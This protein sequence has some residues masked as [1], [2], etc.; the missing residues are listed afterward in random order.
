MRKSIFVLVFVTT[1]LLAAGQTTIIDS[2]YRDGE[3]WYNFENTDPKYFYRAS[4]VDSTLKAIW[5]KNCGPLQRSKIAYSM[6]DRCDP[7]NGWTLFLG[8]GSWFDIPA[9]VKV[10]FKNNDRV[11]YNNCFVYPPGSNQSVQILRTNTT[12]KT[13]VSDS[14]IIRTVTSDY[15][16]NPRNSKNH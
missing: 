5:Q 16:T 2:F 3:W 7:V 14:L 10:K 1:K 4:A 8:N 15:T 11:N 9:A 12:M 6:P 13:L